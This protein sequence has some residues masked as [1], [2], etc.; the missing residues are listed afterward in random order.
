MEIKYNIP[1][2]KISYYKIGGPAKYL[3]KINN[4]KDLIEAI[5]FIK[6]NKISK[7]LPMGLGAKL[8]ISDNGFDGAVLWFNSSS[9][10]DELITKYENRLT[11]FASVELDNLI[12]FSLQH[13]LT[14]LEWAGGLP[15]TIGAAIRGNIG[16]FG[17][18]IKDICLSAEILDL[19]DPEL[20]IKIIK[21]EVLEFGYRTSIIKQIKTLI[22]VSA[23]FSLVQSGL[24][25]L[26]DARSTYER[27]IQYRND[28]HPIEY[29]S[30]GSVFK[31]IIEKNE[32]EKIIKIWP[33]IQE[34]VLN[35]WHNKV[36]MGYVI[37]R[38]G[39]GGRSQ[40]GAE[41]SLKHSNY[42]INKGGA[43]FHD[44]HSLIE[45]IQKKVIEIFGFTPDPEVQII[46]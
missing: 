34:T 43:T 4:K 30:C 27:N 14:G 28:N 11:A 20:N 13:Q 7:I 37:G 3:L 39:L 40:G 22:V 17:H 12:N 6:S 38:L 29:P 23:S 44:V 1:L 36:A 5:T 16:C 18:D 24:K 41:I 10:N 33:D 9:K 25:D 15:S 21:K 32:M 35:K 46:Y 45:L 8:L 31:N 19:A 42:I 2:S 26:M